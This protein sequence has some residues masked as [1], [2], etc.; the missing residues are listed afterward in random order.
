MHC[1]NIKL[2]KI[3]CNTFLHSAI[4]KSSGSF[5]IM[6]CPI[7]LSLVARNFIQRSLVPSSPLMIWLKNPLKVPVNTKHFFKF[8]NKT[9]NRKLAIQMPKFIQ[10]E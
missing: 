4:N 1:Y 10:V 3:T 7:A 2:L 8:N 9:Y 5:V 6:S